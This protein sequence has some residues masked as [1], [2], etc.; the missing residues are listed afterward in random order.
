MTREESAKIIQIIE[1]TYPSYKPASVKTAIEV[2][3]VI[4]LNV[5]YEIVSSAL[6]SYIRNNNEFA[7]VPGQINEII[8]NAVRPD[9][10]NEEEAWDMV[11]KATENGLYGSE[12]EFDKLPPII[13]K[14]IGS[15]HAIY[16][17]AMMDSTSLSVEKSHFLR[18]YRNEVQKQKNIDNLPN[19]VKGSL[20]QMRANT[21]TFENKQQVAMLEA[22]DYYEDAYSRTVEKFL[23]GDGAE[24]EADEELLSRQ[25][26]FAD[27]LRERLNMPEFEL[28]LEP[29]PEKYD[30]YAIFDEEPERQNVEDIFA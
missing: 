2:W 15:S 11:R 17:M 22:K 28:V 9:A 29:E 24:S 18:N 3:R 27:T 4:F 6:F 13:Q 21:P 23:N 8:N 25:K 10:M 16:T 19:G 20:D 7:P 30:D 12:K 5:S 1:A 26:G 14:T